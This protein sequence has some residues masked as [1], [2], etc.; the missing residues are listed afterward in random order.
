MAPFPTS[1]PPKDPL[2]NVFKI[3]RLVSCSNEVT[4]SVFFPGH[5]NVD[6]VIGN[7][8][9]SSHA[10][11]S[12]R[13]LVV[14]T[15]K[16]SINSAVFWCHQESRSLALYATRTPTAHDYIGS[17]MVL[18]PWKFLFA[19]STYL[20]RAKDLSIICLKYPRHVHL[21]DVWWGNNCGILSHEDAI[22]ARLFTSWIK[23]ISYQWVTYFTTCPYITL[24]INIRDF[25]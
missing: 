20:S 14:Y 11:G 12:N 1:P 10:S 17:S 18:M 23:V 25:L 16:V 7:V 9:C 15:F 6:N 4:S 19:I 22:I 3:Y 5:Y 13:D 21:M 24:N 8:T 2:L